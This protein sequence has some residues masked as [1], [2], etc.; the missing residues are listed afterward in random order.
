MAQNWGEQ[1]EFREINI[2]ELMNTRLS[3]LM[4]GSP[5]LKLLFGG[6]IILIIVII[7]LNSFFTVQPGE[8]GVIQRF[9]KYVSSQPSGMHFKVPF[10]DRVDIVRV[11]KV[12]TEEFGYRTEKVGVRTQYSTR[13]FPEESE[14]LTGDMNI[15][16]LKFA[17]LYKI[18][19]AYAFLF[20]VRSPVKALREASEASMR[21][22]V[23]DRG[24]DEAI[25]SGR[26]EIQ[27]EVKDKIQ[28]ILDSYNSG[29]FIVN[30]KL[31][32]ANPPRNVIAAWDAVNKASQYKEQMKN[33][34]QQKLNEAIPRAEG[35]ASRI[36]AEAEAYKIQRI[37]RAKGEQEKFLNILKEYLQAKEITKRRIFI[38]TMEEILIGIDEKV[39]IDADVSNKI[40]S[41]LNLNQQ[42]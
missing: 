8:E 15:V 30:V 1:P 20:N 32:E 25:T 9:G 39:I 38:E 18:K 33:L 16:D 36:V 35:R 31:Q 23:G 42:Q 5:I 12:E 11:S 4:A 27:I 34:A 10:V 13:N 26:E 3:D 6:A 7:A 21:Q 24:I 22:I 19:D 40:F 29:I 17:V 2:G 37:N 41:L 28:K 14:M